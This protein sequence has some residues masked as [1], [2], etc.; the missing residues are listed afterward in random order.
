LA[1][2]PVFPKAPNLFLFAGLGGFL[3]ALLTLCYAFTKTVSNGVR[4][5]VD[6]IGLSGGF[7]L[8]NLSPDYTAGTPIS[9]LD[10]DLDLLRRLITHHSKPEGSVKLLLVEGNGPD[11]SSDL[12]L[13]LKKQGISSIVVPLNFD[14]LTPT[15]GTG[16]LQYLEGTSSNLP[17]IVIENG[18]SR[19]VVGGVS[20]FSAE[21]TGSQKF[22][23]Y[24]NTLAESYK[25]VI[26]VTHATA[27]DAE[28]EALLSTFD[29]VAV[30]FQ[31]ER[32]KQLYPYLENAQASFLG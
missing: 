27:A 17:E 12:A 1:I 18:V 32:L 25:W 28:A 16:L 22:K 23:D 5:T 20:R 21:L 4:A 30:T 31:N 11:Y 6:N 2:T 19:V 24:I 9:L 10:E 14:Q 13:L 7:T 29:Q 15:N 8:G 3:G 26:G